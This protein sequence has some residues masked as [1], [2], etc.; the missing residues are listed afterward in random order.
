[1]NHLFMRVYTLFYGSPL[2]LVTYLQI[3]FN[4]PASDVN[5]SLDGAKF[6]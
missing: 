4:I 6:V 3:W 1:M 2:D 5:K